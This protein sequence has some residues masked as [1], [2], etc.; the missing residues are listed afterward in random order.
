MEENLYIFL[1]IIIGCIYF[2]VIF[3]RD[4]RYFAAL[5]NVVFALYE[6][7]P[8][9][10]IFLPEE[11]IGYR[12]AT[13]V[14]DYSSMGQADTEMLSVALLGF[15]I[16]TNCGFLGLI[17]LAANTPFAL[18][19]LD[20]SYKVIPRNKL[21]DP[22]VVVVFLSAIFL[23]GVVAFFGD[24]G[25]KRLNDY[26]GYSEAVTPFYFYGI[27]LLP[28]A[29]LMLWQI[30]EDDRFGLVLL[31]LIACSP[32]AYE[33]F[34][35]SRRQFLLP[36]PVTLFLYWA[37][38]GAS[39]RQT[40]F[41]TIYLAVAISILFYVQYSARVLV[42]ESQTFTLGGLSESLDIGDGL[43][44]IFSPLIGEVVAVASIT[45]AVFST[46]T[47]AQV[48]IGLQLVVTMLNSIPFL[49]IGDFIFPNYINSLLDSIVV[50]APYGA[51]PLAAELMLSFGTSAFVFFG[52][53]ISIVLF[54]VEYSC[55]R[56]RDSWS[57]LGI[58]L[59]PY[60]AILL[61]KYRGGL[62][63]MIQFTT[64]YFV[65]CGM[66]LLI[67]MILNRFLPRTG[68]RTSI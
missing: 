24:A 64:P 49:K 8:P 68:K 10:T 38:M 31:G 48:T 29:A 54:L 2:S 7:I 62:S 65:L 60:F 20:N 55:V 46:M 3:W 26:I 59:L 9:F 27:M 51:F 6:A 23:F 4:G 14:A 13:A 30:Y 18:K 12:M 43:I 21:W 35:S 45:Y 52:I 22:G 33:I 40:I 36:I 67:G 19:K 58:I 32:I 56:I 1:V 53:V 25:A 11:L 39:F 16:I 42:Q 37:Y 15:L 61:V 47:S 57:G 66:L 41:R 50:F 5:A 63:D 17:A 28:I 44:E 34:V